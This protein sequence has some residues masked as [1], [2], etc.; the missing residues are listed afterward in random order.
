MYKI[1]VAT[2]IFFCLIGAQ[3]TAAEQDLPSQEFLEFLGD[4]SDEDDRW[5]DPA[6]LDGI[7]IPEQERDSNE[8]DK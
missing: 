5:L 6:E 4:W 1:F 3:V 7:E 8:A 2:G